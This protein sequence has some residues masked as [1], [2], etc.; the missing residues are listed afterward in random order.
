MGLFIKLLCLWA[1]IKFGT[2]NAAFRSRGHQ[3]TSDHLACPFLLAPIGHCRNEVIPTMS[4]LQYIT[5]AQYCA[6]GM[7]GFLPIKESCAECFCAHFTSHLGPKNL[8]R[9]DKLPH[10]SKYERALTG[11][12]KSL[13][14]AKYLQWLLTD[15]SGLVIP[16][17]PEPKPQSISTGNHMLK[18]LLKVL[19]GFCMAVFVFSVLGIIAI[20]FARLY[21]H[22]GRTHN[23]RTPKTRSAHPH[24]SHEKQKFISSSKGIK[25]KVTGTDAETAP[26]ESSEQD[27]NGRPH[28]K[29][30]KVSGD[31]IETTVTGHDI[32]GRP[33]STIKKISGDGIEIIITRHDTSGR[34]HRTIKKISRNGIQTTVIDTSES[35]EETEFTPNDAAGTESAPNGR[36]DRKA[37]AS[38]DPVV[39]SAQLRERIKQDLD[40]KQN[41]ST[42]S[43]AST[44]ASSEEDAVI[45]TPDGSEGEDGFVAV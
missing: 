35:G 10:R 20:K 24:S 1:A 21:R 33:H 27:T 37:A 5:Y 12:K 43:T 22:S 23:A 25:I 4:P 42:D 15:R 16:T 31:G 2:S 7:N 11:S 41:A 6:Y 34:P 3:D 14:G 18:V 36:P 26:K 19:K 28:R 30:T 45:N 38:T 9:W 29:T 32:D 44:K 13:S 17:L 8:D 40:E 39:S